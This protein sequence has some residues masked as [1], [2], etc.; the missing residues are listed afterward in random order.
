[1]AVKSINVV[2]AGAGFMGTAH[3][4]AYLKIPGVR[5]VGLC[6]PNRPVTNGVL[7]GVAGNIQQTNALRLPASVKVVR[8]FDDLLALPNV[9]AVDICTPTS[10]HPSQAIAAL[11]S[12]KHVLC[13]KPLAESSAEAR[14]V[15]KAASKSKGILMPAMCMRFWPGWE[16]LKQII[17]SRKYGKVLAASFR[18]VSERPAWGDAASHPGGAL[19]DFHIHDADFAQFLFGRPDKVFATGVTAANG[20][21]E[22]VVAQFVYRHGP[23]VV[24]EGSWLVARGFNM[25]YM[26]QCEN[27]TL[28]YDFQRGP[29]ARITTRDGKV[30]ALK[31]L[32]GD[33][34]NAEIRHFVDCVRRRKPSPI[35]PPQDAVAALEICEAEEKS[36]RTGAPVKL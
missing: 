23:S 15:L 4:R 33:G 3:L 12:G 13:E 7:G 29:E 16:T 35:V 36:L 6:S 5:V 8:T 25:G 19:L 20:T 1:M 17:D 10:L 34:Y 26:V 28:D 24:A 9:D 21:V 11:L 31:N 14:A 32:A 22:Q 27:A 2:I 18:R 30:H